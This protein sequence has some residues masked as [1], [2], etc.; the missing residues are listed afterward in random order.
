[1][2]SFLGSSEDNETVATLIDFGDGQMRIDRPDT[3]NLDA[4]DWQRRLGRT[5][6]GDRAFE[7][8]RDA[9]GDS[10]D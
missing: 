9:H 6:Q 8:W 7:A 10:S 3:Q 4:A 5:P 1:M 2:L